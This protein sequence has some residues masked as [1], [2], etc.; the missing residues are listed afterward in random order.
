MIR[1][2]PAFG[3]ALT[4]V[5]VLTAPALV[6]NRHDR[7]QAPRYMLSIDIRSAQDAVQVFRLSVHLYSDG[8]D[9]LWDGLAAR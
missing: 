9:F 7:H 1:P 5:L 6:N 3:L 2:L 4:A 8:V